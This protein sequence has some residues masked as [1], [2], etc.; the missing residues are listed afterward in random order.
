MG[1]HT[2]SRRKGIH[3]VTAREE[4]GSTKARVVKENAHG[5]GKVG[6]RGW[7]VDTTVLHCVQKGDRHGNGK[8]TACRKGEAKEGKGVW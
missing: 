7:E 2:H 6:R 5:E 3:K 1:R 8:P 4:E